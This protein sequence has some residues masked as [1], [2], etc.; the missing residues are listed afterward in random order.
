[1]KLLS[2]EIVSLEYREQLQR[3]LAKAS[4][5]RFVVAYISAEGM[6]SIGRHLLTRGL[7][8]ARSFGIGSLSCSC[9]YEPLLRLQAE[10]PELRLKYFMDPLV[11]EDG[12][13]S[14][15][16][17]F[18]SKLVYLYLE[19][20]AKSVV[21]IGSHNW[22]R[23]ALGPQ[24]P[25]N[26]EASIRF[27]S[28]FAP[29][30]LDGSGSTV[31]SHVNRHLLDA[32][33]MPLCLPATQGN[34][35]TFREWFEKG[36]R[37]TPS[38]PLKESTILLAVRRGNAGDDDMLALEGRGIYLQVLDEDDGRQVWESDNRLLVLV[39]N[40]D[41][42]LAAA[43]QPVMLQCR[44]TT[45][46]AGLNSQ[47]RGTNQSLAPVAGFEAVIW[48]DAELTAQRSSRRDRRPPVQLW[49]GREVQVYDFEFPTAYLDSSQV[50]GTV[51]P[52]YQFH[53]EIERVV[54]PTTGSFSKLP[55]FL[56]SP[57][58]FSVAASR[59]AAR[60]EETPGY[61]VE[62]DR[63]RQIMAFLTDVLFVE[64]EEAKVLPYSNSDRL[65][66]GKRISTHPLHETFLGPEWKEKK[67]R[68]EYY[69]KSEPGALV[70]ELDSHADSRMDMS[71]G[72]GREDLSRLQRVFTTPIE[73]LAD[74][75]REAARL[76]RSRKDALEQGGKETRSPESD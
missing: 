71:Q 70:A 22:T 6:E 56:W 7:R 44:I 59:D 23:R 15:I 54:M 3:D 33:N 64:P 41:A 49:S 25:R 62:P 57:E 8:D 51:R 13:P 10:M 65:K 27:E 11:K 38:A 42:E 4:V 66:V 40:S 39:W 61:Y 58:S 35:P 26:A 5:C 37:R 73:R 53:L 9:G 76:W 34:E 46:K 29:E 45:S 19:R 28:D 2:R 55:E 18:H 60:V 14:E 67:L 24:G 50:D 43:R 20:E 17:L 68:D 36:C 63:E 32:W 72:D 16:S 52:K 12:E 47:L 21:Y 30:D 69:Q 48:D 75:W 1:L 31:A 74:T